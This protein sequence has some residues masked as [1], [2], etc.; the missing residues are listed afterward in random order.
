MQ[1]VAE[2]ARRCRDAGVVFHTD[3]VQAFGK[4]PVSLERAALYP[5]HPF[6]AQDRRAQGHRAR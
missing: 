2:I 6:R 5:A 4:V 3:A 1:P